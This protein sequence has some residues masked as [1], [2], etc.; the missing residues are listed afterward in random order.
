[1]HKNLCRVGFFIKN[2]SLIF[3]HLPSRDSS[4]DG[5]KVSIVHALN[6]CKYNHL[7]FKVL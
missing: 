2:W 6:K 7:S 3:F 4:K 1:M 5:L